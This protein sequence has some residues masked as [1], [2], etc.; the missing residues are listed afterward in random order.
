MANTDNCRLWPELH[1]PPC[2]SAG[3]RWLRGGLWLTVDFYHRSMRDT[4]IPQAHRSKSAQQTRRCIMAPNLSIFPRVLHTS[5][6]PLKAYA[7][8]VLR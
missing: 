8:D 4:P 5:R 6:R 7:Y 3:Y 2:N 1:V